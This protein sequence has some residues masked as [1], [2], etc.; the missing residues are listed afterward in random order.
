MPRPEEP[1][2]APPPRGRVRH[3]P[4]L[5]PLLGP[6]RRLSR[7]GGALYRWA[8]RQWRQLRPAPGGADAP[9][10]KSRLFLLA[11]ML[12]GAYHGTLVMT[13]AYAR[14]D[15][16]GSLLFQAS[17]YARNL[18][19]PWDDRWYGG[20]PL[21]GQ[22]PLVPQ[23]IA[24][25]TAPLGVEGAFG[26][27]Q[28]LSVA[29]LVW[30]VYRVTLTGAT[31]MNSAA[32]S[33]TQRPSVQVT[34]VQVMTAQSLAAPGLAAQGTAR[35][36]AGVAALLCTLSS[37]LTLQLN[38][39]GHHGSVLG[40]ALALHAAPSLWAWLR[41]PAGR[42]RRAFGQRAAL[43]LLAAGTADPASALLIGLGALLA[44]LPLGALRPPDLAPPD[45]A[46]TDLPGSR[47]DQGRGAGRAVLAGGLLLLQYLLSGWAGW[48]WSPGAALP[49]AAPL[50]WGRSAWLCLGLPLWSVLWTL[51]AL[52]GVFRSGPRQWGLA[53]RLALLAAP[54]LTLCALGLLSFSPLRVPPETLAFLAALL[55][56]PLSAQ[57]VLRAWDAAR[58]VGAQLPLMLAAALTLL[59]TVGLNALPRTRVLEGP[60]VNLQPLLNFIEKDEHWRYRYLTV[61]FG[62]Q[63]GLL[64][65]QT[66][67][68]TTAG[69][70]HLPPDLPQLAPAPT[71]YAALPERAVLPGFGSFAEQLTHPE[72]A[73]LKFVYARGS[74]MDPLLYLHGW[75]NI[76]TLENGVSVWEREDVP[77]IPA[78]LPR[79]ALPL[80]VAVLWGVGPLLALTL[81]VLAVL[82]AGQTERRVP[83]SPP[84]GPLHHPAWVGDLP[85]LPVTAASP[86]DA[87]QVKR[88]ATL[89]V[90][91]VVLTVL[92]ALL[93]ASGLRFVPGWVTARTWAARVAH[94]PTGG[95]L[96][97]EYA[98]L[99]G[100]QVRLARLSGGAR[101]GLTAHVT[102]R[103][104]TPL[105]T[106][107]TYPSGPLTLGTGGWTLAPDTPDA[108]E[109]RPG[110]PAAQPNVAYYRA[111]RRIT[112]NATAP[113]DV[114]D[115]PVVQ[116]LSA[117]TVLT[118]A[119]VTAVG[120]LLNADARPADLTLGAT[121][122]GPAGQVLAQEN[123]GLLGVHKLRPGERTPWQVTLPPLPPG[124]DPARV[125]LEVAARAVVTGRNLDRSLSARSRVTAGGAGGRVSVQARNVS[126]RTVAAPQALLTLYDAR[127]VAW[128]Y[129]A[130]GPEL[131]PGQSWTFSLPA[132]PPA[133]S[134]LLRVEPP[135][136]P[137]D[138]TTVTPAL[139]A[140]GSFP[141]PGGGFYSLAFQTLTATGAP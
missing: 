43:P 135:P 89:P 51:P 99:D 37:A 82:V 44:G 41:A 34:S 35:R 58:Q 106:R 12:T 49:P 39:F 90:R 79:S 46:P 73:Y 84:H 133:G 50:A 92:A 11:L 130:L 121:L 138:G 97:G 29:L 127:G 27:A 8:Q 102:A 74:V 28:F 117:R 26:A 81:A 87:R 125:T 36:V 10:L 115:R 120:E 114:L 15:G 88:A 1:V 54:L 96:R 32:R 5:V 24:L 45:L 38:V 141:L 139:T 16:V 31:L 13:R 123:L 18:F 107:T 25:L 122:R 136:R 68:A 134:R 98:R 64:S 103:W 75:H 47:P 61:G 53:A 112:T 91:V 110:V 70:W 94:P 80:P 119:R 104:W 101:L 124:T 128:V 126:V 118:G 17:A 116:V 20:V 85:P 67:A 78:R 129:S 71:A 83:I 111:P 93:V 65:A 131:R 23:L 60:A 9:R 22:P 56:L 30:A 62:R 63:L 137:Y 55:L 76:G 72:R 2:S 86:A 140:P 42:G 33:Q 109:L 66:R 95:G 69:L 14:G 132:A 4:A 108:V 105:G 77:P 19:D 48:F 6:A 7:R 59:V 100:F 3:L 57:V 52:P 21:T 40:A 113:A